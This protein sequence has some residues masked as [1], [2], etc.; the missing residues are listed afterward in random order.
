MS[1]PTRGV[2]HRCTSHPWA[3]SKAHPMFVAMPE[4][5][6]LYPLHQLEKQHN[7]PARGKCSW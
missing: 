1:T 7:F 3:L 4:H 6:N 2:R 5:P